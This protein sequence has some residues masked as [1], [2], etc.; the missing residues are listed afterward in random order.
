MFSFEIYGP[1]RYLS[2][3]DGIGAAHLA[4]QHLGWECVGVSE[5]APFPAAVV[6][7]H[8]GFRNFGNMRNYKRWPQGLLSDVDVLVGG[9]PCQ[10]FSVAGKRRSLGD[11]RGTLIQV[12]VDLFRHIN[13]IRR[14]HGRPPAI[15]IFENVPG[16]LTP[17]DNPFG[18][19]LG[20]L[21]GLDEAPETQKGKWHRAGL[22][23]SKTMRVGW[24]V[25]DA[26]YFAVA[27]RRR[28]VFL[29]AMPSELVERFGEGAC[30]SQI[31]SLPESVLGSPAPRG[32]GRQE[33][34]RSPEDCIDRRIAGGAA[35]R[36]DREIPEVIAF[37]SNAQGSQLPSRCRDTSI[38]DTLTTS[39]RAAVV[40]VHNSKE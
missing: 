5:I 7:H 15:A 29:V 23:R 17:P 32:A 31:L 12:Y 20:G 6:D 28:R 25:L 19:L 33:T 22:L 26:K 38:A 40:F 24:R 21:L 8:F 2:V 35:E 36:Q 9:P 1:W 34:A 37:N 30:P 4:W 13:A 10:S 3:C 39:Q 16:I 18:R 11:A 27:Q 14:S